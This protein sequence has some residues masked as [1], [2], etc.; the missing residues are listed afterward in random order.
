MQKGG[1][2]A[3]RQQDGFGE[4]GKVQ[5][6]QRLDLAQFVMDLAGEDF[7]IGAGQLHFGR[8][9]RAAGFVAGAALAPERPIADAA[10]FKLHFGQTVG[11]VAGHQ[12]VAAGRH[13]LQPGGAVVERQADGV[14]QGGFAGARGAGDGKQAIAGK[15]RLAK[16]NAKFA[17]ER[18][19]VFQAQREDFHQAVSASSASTWR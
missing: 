13:R 7:A 15:R 5:A 19:Q 9:Q 17:L 14:Q 8:L 18:V 4:A 11:G 3:L 12:L 1:K 10:H 16:I 6:G 2:T